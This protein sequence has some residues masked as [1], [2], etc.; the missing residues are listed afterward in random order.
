MSLCRVLLSVCVSSKTMKF[1]NAVI[2]V[3]MGGQA[4]GLQALEIPAER[5]GSN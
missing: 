2:M 3:I 5:Y 4:G 1:R